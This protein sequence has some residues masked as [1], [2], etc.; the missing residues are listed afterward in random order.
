MAASKAWVV[1]GIVFAALFRCCSL[2]AA[3]L[4]VDLRV[5]TNVPPRPVGAAKG[6]AAALCRD[7]GVT[8]AWTTAD[9]PD[10]YDPQ[11]PWRRIVVIDQPTPAYSAALATDRVL[12]ISP[13][14][15]EEPGRI[16]VIFFE[17]VRRTS[18]QARIPSG[19]LL[20]YAIAHETAH[21]LLPAGHAGTGVMRASWS[22]ADLHRLATRV[23]A[24]DPPRAALIRRRLADQGS[25]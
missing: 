11:M 5:Q 8:I 4:V 20:G 22:G 15:F 19:S 12:G 3:A 18:Q 25:G 1:S 10:E 2:E 17:R 6:V 14:T 9:S 16:G 21:L 24:F 13:R 23:L 7:I